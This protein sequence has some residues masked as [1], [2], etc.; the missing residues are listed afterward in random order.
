MREFKDMNRDYHSIDGDAY[1][2]KFDDNFDHTIPVCTQHT[3]ENKVQCSK[4][5]FNF[6]EVSPETKNQYKLF[7]YPDENIFN[8]NPILGYINQKAS[9]HLSY[10]NA[11]NGYRKQLHMMLLVFNDQPLEA[12]LFQESYWK[13]GNKNEFIVCVGLRG[14][15]INWTRVISWT[16]KE[17]LKIRVARQIKE[18]KEFDAVKV[19]DYMGATIP[20]GFVRKQFADF[21][22]LSVEPTMTAVLWTFGITF[23]VTLIIMLIAVF[24]EHNLGDTFGG[25]RY[26]YRY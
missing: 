10:Y 14:N 15:K 21:N 4:S 9:G 2:T 8:F 12:G 24:N 5:V 16:D 20:K 19:V 1:V 23:V 6:D 3:Y 11:H 7:D 17:E 13:G 18:M 25:N 22:Y 26:R